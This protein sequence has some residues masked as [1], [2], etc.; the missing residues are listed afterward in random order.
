[1][2]QAIIQTINGLSRDQAIEAARLVSHSLVGDEPIDER[3]PALQAIRD[4]PHAHLPDLENL[5]RLMLICVASTTEGAAEVERAIAEM[6]KK[7]L[8]LDGVDIVTL[9]A[10][11][12][13]AL[14]IIVTRGHEQTPEIIKFLDRE[15]KLYAEVEQI[16]EPILITPELATILRGTL[17]L[18]GPSRPESTA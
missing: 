7:Q 15:G 14:S 8:I 2:T 6:D 9:A 12:V 4:H 16:E 18:G 10:L 3:H 17:D 5:A 1:M 11:G 13:A